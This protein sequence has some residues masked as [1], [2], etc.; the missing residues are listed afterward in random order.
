MIQKNFTITTEAGLHARPSTVLVS[1]ASSFK[2]DIFIEYNNKKVNFKSIMGVMSLGVSQNSI[3]TISAEG[4]DE[5]EALQ[6]IEET[7]LKEKLGK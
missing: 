2:S 5:E 4:V 1:S 7:M 6:T 3:V